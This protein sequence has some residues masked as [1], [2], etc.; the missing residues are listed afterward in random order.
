[1][2]SLERKRFVNG[3]RQLKEPL[4]DLRSHLCYFELI[5]CNL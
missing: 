3:V 5:E 4:L 1:M 2:S